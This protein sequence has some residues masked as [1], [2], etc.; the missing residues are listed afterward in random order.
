M[1][2][3]EK[4]NANVDETEIRDSGIPNF[5]L[6]STLE[7]LTHVQAIFDRLESVDEYI[8][9]RPSLFLIFT[10]L[11]YFI[12]D[13]YIEKRDLWVWPKWTVKDNL[14]SAEIIFDNIRISYEV[15]QDFF[16]CILE[17]GLDPDTFEL[18]Q[19]RDRIH[20]DVLIHD[21]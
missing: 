9:R 15:E 14:L 7:Q 21:Q 4:R 19:I 3:P 1:L 16:N 10:A 20:T 11:N 12:D 6:E 13:G 17:M 8:E 2:I 5:M 18:Q